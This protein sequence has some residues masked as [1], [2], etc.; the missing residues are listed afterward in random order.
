MCSELS[1]RHELS[2]ENILIFENVLFLS[3][4]SKL[5][6]TQTIIPAGGAVGHYAFFINFR[7]GV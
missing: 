5:I 6:L 4:S 1:W 2:E 3:S 7:D